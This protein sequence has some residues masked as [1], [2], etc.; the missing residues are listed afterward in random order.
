MDVE[1]GIEFL[2]QSQAQLQASQAQFQAQVEAAQ[3]RSD[4][5]HARLGQSV[6][7]LTGVVRQLAQAQIRTEQRVHEIATYQI[8]LARTQKEQSE[9]SKQTR[10]NL[11]ALIR[12]VDGFIRGNGKH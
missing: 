2:L 5:S 6:L 12:V 4:E 1:K 7:D 8:E 3:A 11:D 9:S 10:E